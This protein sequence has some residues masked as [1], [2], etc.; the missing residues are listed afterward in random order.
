MVC[1]MTQ[2]NPLTSTVWCFIWNGLHVEFKRRSKT[3]KTGKNNFVS[4]FT[5]IPIEICVS[6]KMR[7]FFSLVK[8]DKQNTK[9]SL[10]FTV[11]SLF[12]WFMCR[13]LFA[14]RSIYASIQF[15][16][17]SCFFLF[18]QMFEKF[19]LFVRALSVSEPM[20]KYNIM[21]HNATV[22][23]VELLTCE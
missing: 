23:T 6:W 5:Q 2:K 22:S 21:E 13:K 15:T 7:N 16:K 9:D 14:Q 8:N 20:H 4:I 1:Q 17:I 3:K 18:P 12:V 19:Y 10:F 11:S